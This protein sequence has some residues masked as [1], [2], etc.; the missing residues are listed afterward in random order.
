MLRFVDKAGNEIDRK[1]WLELTCA[2]KYSKVKETE[3]PGITVT[4]SWCGV[5]LTDHEL[6]PEPFLVSARLNGCS[7]NA[8]HR[9]KVPCWTWCQTEEQAL[10]AHREFVRDLRS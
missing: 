6:V 7:M 2:P 3:L 9:D 1:Q 5:W 10:I 8:A 4:T